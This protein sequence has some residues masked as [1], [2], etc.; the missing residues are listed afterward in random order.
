MDLSLARTLYYW[1]KCYTQRISQ[2]E[3]W[4]GEAIEAIAAGKGASVISTTGN[5]MT[6]SFST[7]SLTNSEWAATLA[8]AL[9]M[10]ERGSI[11]SRAIGTVI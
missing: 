9:E 2:L 4:L 5:G 7:K 11:S 6:V 1:C 3:D 10:I 8:K